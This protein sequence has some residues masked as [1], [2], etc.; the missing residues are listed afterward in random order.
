[1]ESRKTGAEAGRDGRVT[2]QPNHRASAGSSG[3]GYPPRDVTR[4][5][6]R[7]PNTVLE[8]FKHV[9]SRY[10]V[11]GAEMIMVSILAPDESTKIHHKHRSFR[12]IYTFIFSRF[13]ILLI[14]HGKILFNYLYC[15]LADEV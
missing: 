3:T 5:A 9:I 6:A 12:E 13:R 1:M 4:P 7:R 11:L 2:F 14:Y 8:S 10:L 15:L